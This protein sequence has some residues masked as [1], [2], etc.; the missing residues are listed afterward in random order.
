MFA[1]VGVEIGTC[2]KYGR[3]RAMYLALHLFVQDTARLVL[4]ETT[5]PESALTFRVDGKLKAQF[6]EAARKQDRAGSQILREFMRKFVMQPAADASAYDEWFRASVQEAL[7][8]PRPAV[9]SALVEG[10]FAKRRAAA[11]RK[12]GRRTR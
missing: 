10:Q 9:P 7:D 2:G 4:R 1:N 6:F 3:D 8:D 11:K 12:Y 5:M